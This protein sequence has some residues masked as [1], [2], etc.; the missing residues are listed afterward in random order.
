MDLIHI[1][2]GSTIGIKKDEAKLCAKKSMGDLGGT[3]EIHEELLTVIFRSNV[4][5]D[6]LV[7]GN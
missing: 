7:I 6:L 2:C 3:S 4:F 1:D 5:E